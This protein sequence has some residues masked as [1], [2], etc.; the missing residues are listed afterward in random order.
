MKIPIHILKVFARAVLSTKAY[1]LKVFARTVLSTKARNGETWSYHYT[2]KTGAAVVHRDLHIKA[3]FP[4][5]IAW[6]LLF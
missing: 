1:I 5:D 4:I 2:S 3:T 6:C